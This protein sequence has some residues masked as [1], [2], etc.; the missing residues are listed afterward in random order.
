MADLRMPEINSVVLTGNLT[1]DPVLKSTQNGSTVVFFT[2][3]T[4]KRY[5]KYNDERKEEVSFIGVIARNKLAE[6]CANFLKKG[7]AV[8]IE[9]E[10]QSRIWKVD[11]NNSHTV[12]ELKA[13]RIQ[14]LKKREKLDHEESE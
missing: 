12:V 14:F 7:S 3:A 4:N 1:R 2:V 8:L 11:E 9:G 13:R 10:L 5:R 6:S